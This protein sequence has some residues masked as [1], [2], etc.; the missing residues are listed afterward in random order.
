MTF[1]A[2]WQATQWAVDWRVAMGLQPCSSHFHHII[3]L[4]NLQCCIK[5]QRKQYAKGFIRDV[6]TGGANQLGRRSQSADKRRKVNVFAEQNRIGV[7]SLQ[8]DGPVICAAQSKISNRVCVVTQL[9]AQPCR[10]L[11]RQLRVEPEFCHAYAASR[12]ISVRC[13]A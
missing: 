6:P 3:T 13:A 7:A 11:R 5:P 1:N 9:G 4:K 12:I 2:A 10:Q 8:K